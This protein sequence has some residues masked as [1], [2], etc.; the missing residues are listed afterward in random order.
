[1]E[2]TA[3]I[4]GSSLSRL[5][6]LVPKKYGIHVF[7]FAM[8]V[9]VVRIIASEHEPH[10]LGL[11]FSRDLVRDHLLEGSSFEHGRGSSDGHLL[12]PASKAENAHYVT[13]LPPGYSVKPTAA[14][15]SPRGQ[16]KDW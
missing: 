9:S 7:L 3:G 10:L 11:T 6:I 8:R 1:M 4:L 2:F 14:T 13:P 16:A 12:R 5:E 15:S